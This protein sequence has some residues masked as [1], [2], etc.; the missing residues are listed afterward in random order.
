MAQNNLVLRLL[1][2]S[3]SDNITKVCL[4]ILHV[5]YLKHFR[6][7]FSIVRLFVSLSDL[8]NVEQKVGFKFEFVSQK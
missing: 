3:L 7:F 4:M 1:Q 6:K 8:K 2:S 5:D